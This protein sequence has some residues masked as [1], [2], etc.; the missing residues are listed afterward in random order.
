MSDLLLSPSSLMKSAVFS[1]LEG[2]LTNCFNAFTFCILRHSRSF[3]AD[4][5]TKKTDYFH[6]YNVF[7]FFVK[8]VL[9]QII[10]YS[11]LG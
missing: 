9:I 6:F 8:N 4:L 7:F 2:F 10:Y 5:I 1:A 11:A 3:L